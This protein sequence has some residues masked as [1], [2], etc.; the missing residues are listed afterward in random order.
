[1]AAEMIALGSTVAGVAT[2]VLV[3][4]VTIPIYEGFSFLISSGCGGL[5]AAYCQNRQRAWHRALVKLR[6]GKVL[7]EADKNELESLARNDLE[8][9]QEMLR[10]AQ[11]LHKG[12]DIALADELLRILDRARPDKNVFSECAP[13]PEVMN[14]S[15][16]EDGSVRV[17]SKT[18]SQLRHRGDRSK[19][20]TYSQEVSNQTV[21]RRQEVESRLVAQDPQRAA[22]RGTIPSGQG[23]QVGGSAVQHGG[24]DQSSVYPPS[25]EIPSSRLGGHP[26]QS[27]GSSQGTTLSAKESP[28]NAPVGQNN[29]AGLPSAFPYSPS[30]PRAGSNIQGSASGRETGLL[31]PGRQR[32]GPNSLASGSSQAPVTPRGAGAAQ[33]LGS[34]TSPSGNQAEPRPRNQA[35]TGQ[36]PES[37]HNNAMQSVTS[38]TGLL[39]LVRRRK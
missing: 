15:I 13:R 7:N 33:T 1:M 10:V 8:S 28:L 36:S 12:G 17:N 35:R 18:P 26:A 22:P 27:S 21:A 38:K 9:F 20:T 2:G 31:V 29:S 4:K 34:G 24:S 3:C 30:P 37:S 25:L 5:T 23:P 16:G 19:G 11:R 14:R 39:G 6:D 32:G